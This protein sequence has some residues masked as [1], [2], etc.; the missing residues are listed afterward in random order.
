MSAS[1]SPQQIP[2][3][4]VTIEWCPVCGRNDRYTAFT[5]KSHF[6][7]YGR[8]PGHPVVVTYAYKKEEPAAGDTQ[9][10]RLSL[11]EEWKR[12][13]TWLISRDGSSFER[14]REA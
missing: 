12:T 6:T 2:P 13:R 11:Q 4:V 9:Q 14:R 7:P 1:K 5:G 10:T 8:C 3:A